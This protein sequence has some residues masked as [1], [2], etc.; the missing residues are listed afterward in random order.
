M[1]PSVSHSITVRLEVASH[2]RAASELTRAVG[3][4]GA[5]RAEAA[6][7]G[8]SGAGVEPDGPAAIR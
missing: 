4:V 7:A 5:A 3:A 2:G 6:A 8:E 1:T